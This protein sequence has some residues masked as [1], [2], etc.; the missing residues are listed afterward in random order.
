MGTRLPLAWFPNR[1][2][3]TIR[4]RKVDRHAMSYAARG[5]QPY[6]DTWDEAHRWLIDKVGKDL[7]KASKEVESQRKRFMRVVALTA[8]S[9][10]AA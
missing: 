10:E 1:Y 3:A 6:F 7:E 9:A 4:R 8:P 5:I 2:M